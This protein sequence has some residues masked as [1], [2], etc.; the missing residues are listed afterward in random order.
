MGYVALLHRY[1]TF[2]Q[3]RPPTTKSSARF[4]RVPEDGERRVV[5][6]ANYISLPT[7][8]LVGCFAALVSMKSGVTPDSQTNTITLRVRLVG[9]LVGVFHR[10]A[11]TLLLC[12][13]IRGN[14]VRTTHLNGCKWCR[15]HWKFPEP[16]GRHRSSR[17]SCQV[18]NKVLYKLCFCG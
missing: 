13:W 4:L 10:T 8:G 17:F 1:E 6:Y 16:G 2:D 14:M 11:A 7:F 3:T 12:L 9:W 18:L 15:R 5:Q